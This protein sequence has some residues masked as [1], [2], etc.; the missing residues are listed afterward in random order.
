M[1]KIINLQVYWQTHCDQKYLVIKKADKEYVNPQATIRSLALDIEDNFLPKEK[2]ALVNINCSP[3]FEISIRYGKNPKHNQ[4]LSEEEE[5]QLF[6][7]L[8]D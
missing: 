2:D 6:K 1:S 3:D 4:A 8:H 7:E 5:V